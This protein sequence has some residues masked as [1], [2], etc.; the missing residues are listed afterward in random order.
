MRPS[1][2]LNE[3]T[4]TLANTKCRASGNSLDY[5]QGLEELGCLLS[6]IKNQGRS[7]YW[8]G[9]GGSNAI[10]SHLSQDIINKLRIPSY[11]V[12]DPA[13]IT[14]M[15]NDYGFENIFSTPLQ[16]LLKENDLLIAI[17]SSGN[18]A[19]ILNAINI[20]QEKGSKIVALSSFSANNK[21]FSQ[22]CDLSFH[23]PANLYGHAEL[24]HA[25]IIHSV[26]ECMALKK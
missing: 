6:L 23:L 26:V 16:V 9:N 14:C 19:N 4:N 2:W 8:V 25:A 1:D 12:N 18:S 17:S 13:L 7:V 11:V 3:F 21:L 15:G 20:A 5:E 24:G 10:C 22:D